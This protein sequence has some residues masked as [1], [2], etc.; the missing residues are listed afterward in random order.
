[1]MGAEIAGAQFE[2]FGPTLDAELQGPVD[3]LECLFGGGAG[4]RVAGL[5]DPVEN[6]AS[7]RLLFCFIAEKRILESD[8]DVGRV[9]KH[10]LAEL[11][12]SGVSFAD[13]EQC[14]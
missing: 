5:A 13:F 12:A 1:M 6:P 9:E 4:G 14:V 3:I 11:I 10:S 8:V 2:R 7:L